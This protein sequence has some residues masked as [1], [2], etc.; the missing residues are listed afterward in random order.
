[1]IVDAAV[2]VAEP[3][4][5]AW[6]LTFTH[7]APLAK[8]SGS[9]PCFNCLSQLSAYTRKKEKTYHDEN[10]KGHNELVSRRVTF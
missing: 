2:S 8:V 3:E 4:T 1:M 7:L 10:E 9:T 5:S 6:I